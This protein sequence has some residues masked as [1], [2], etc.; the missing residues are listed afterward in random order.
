MQQI[1]LVFHQIFTRRFL[2][3]YLTHLQ[4]TDS[5]FLPNKFWHILWLY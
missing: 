5:L 3:K 2:L 1:N 4:I